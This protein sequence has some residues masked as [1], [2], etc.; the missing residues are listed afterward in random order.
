MTEKL[1][2]VPGHHVVHRAMVLGDRVEPWCNARALA[3]AVEV[4]DRHPGPRCQRCW[5]KPT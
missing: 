3:D 5:G 4:S 2:V 1:C